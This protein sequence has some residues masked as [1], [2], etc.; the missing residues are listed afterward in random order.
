MA[1]GQNFYYQDPSEAIGSSLARAIMGDPAMAQKQQQMRAEAAL[2]DAQTEQARQHARL[3]GNQATE[4]E[5]Q[6]GSWD[7]VPDLIARYAQ[8]MVPQAAPAQQAAPVSPFGQMFS[9]ETV[10]SLP[11]VDAGGALPEVP[12]IPAPEP[13]V[14]RSAMA[15]QTLAELVGHFARAKGDKV[16][17]PQALGPLM[18]L[19][20]TDEMS[21]AALI[22]RGQTPG[23]SFA[24]D[25]GRAD[26]IAAR[27]AAAKQR[28]AYGVASINHGNDIPIANI[29]AGSARDVATINH[30][31]DIPVANIKAGSV[32]DVAG[33]KAG[34]PGFDAI[35]AA[36]PGVPMNSGWRSK[37][38]NREVG[39]VSNSAHLGETPGRQGYDIPVQ[40][41][42]TVEEAAARIEEANGGRVRVVEARDERGRRGPNGKPLGGWHFA[43]E[44]VGGK[45]AK[46]AAASA[47]KMV[48]AA[49]AKAIHEEVK[50]Q[51]GGGNFAR[52]TPGSLAIIKKWATQNYQQSGS[53]P[54]AVQ[55]ALKRADQSIGRGGAAPGPKPAANNTPPAPAPAGST[56]KPVNRP[57]AKPVAQEQWEQVGSPKKYPDGNTYG[58]VKS[59]VTGKI[60]W[61]RMIP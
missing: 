60:R 44:G 22:G 32:R 29:R 47:P 30:G 48:P 8:Q 2:R 33:I 26:E 15:R 39:G 17:I 7:G 43:L 35:T 13:V 59:S 56:A 6:T 11:G 27:D 25:A 36:F 28:Q 45:P 3:Y 12:N 34:A 52:A 55:Q 50:A 14:D 10:A 49:G 19:F 42:M 23:A 16:D 40:P 57:A 18:A 1:R 5:G 58:Q 46:P 37:E 31:N 4:Q 38:R 21:R 41:G 54:D 24:I 9:P 20:G 61:A 53:I 51:M